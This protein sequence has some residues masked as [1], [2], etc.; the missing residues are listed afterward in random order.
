MVSLL[1]KS[2]RLTSQLLGRL[3]IVRL[4]NRL[5]RTN[6]QRPAA[7]YRA[8]AKALPNLCSAGS[9]DYGVTRIVEPR[10]PEQCCYLL[11]YDARSVKGLT[12][13]PAEGC[14]TPFL[15]TP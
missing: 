14:T 7:Q 12:N 9:R 2:R 11:A 1:R 4:L 6:G 5:S 3:S 13:P 10:F 15:T 8:E